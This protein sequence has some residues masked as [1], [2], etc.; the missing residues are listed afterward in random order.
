[1]CIIIYYILL[2]K[3]STCI[4]AVTYTYTLPWYESIVIVG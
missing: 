4:T 3:L 1:M 2:T